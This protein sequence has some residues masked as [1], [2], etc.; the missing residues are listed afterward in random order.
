MLQRAI[1]DQAQDHRILHVDMAAEGAGK[2]DAVHLF[3]PQLV[4]QQAHARI[5]RGLGQL[6]GAHVILRDR[7]QRLAIAHHIGEGAAMGCARG[8]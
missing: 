7:D 1:G 8:G 4:H 6:N 3:E 5:E 2:P